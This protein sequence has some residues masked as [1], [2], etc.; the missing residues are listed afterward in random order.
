VCSVLPNS[1][2]LRTEMKGFKSYWWKALGVCLVLATIH[3]GT[4][5]E[6]GPGIV[7]ISPDAVYANEDFQLEIEG[8]N[9]HFSHADVKS[10]EL[11][12]WYK[13]LGKLQKASSVEIIDDN[14][15]LVNFSGVE[16]QTD[17]GLV[18]SAT[19]V[20]ED[21]H[22]GLFLGSQMLKIRFKPNLLSTVDSLQDAEILPQKLELAKSL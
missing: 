12:V 4:S 10:N 16:L 20:I 21:K 7:R 6:V 17:S 22:H 3:L 9:T 1:V 2:S 18:R 19:L 14:Y 13:V 5:T 11:H 15:L 8:Y